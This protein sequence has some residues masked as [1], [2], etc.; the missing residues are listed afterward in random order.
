MMKNTLFII[1]VLMVALSLTGCHSNEQNYREAYEKAAEYRDKIRA[2]E[3]QIAAEE[4]G[5]E[6]HGR[7]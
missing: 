7:A 1:A 4:K 6:A 3:K 2:L 5:G